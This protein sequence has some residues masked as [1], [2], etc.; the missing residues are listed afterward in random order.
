LLNRAREIR[1][2][3][4]W[5]ITKLTRSE[6]VWRIFVGGV[7][8]SSG[9][10][11]RE[12]VVSFFTNRTL[13]EDAWNEMLFTSSPF[14][15]SLPEILGWA[16]AAWAIGYVWLNAVYR[17]KSRDVTPA[18]LKGWERVVHERAIPLTEKTHRFHLAAAAAGLALFACA[19]AVSNVLA[20]GPESTDWL[21]GLLAAWIVG[22]ICAGCYN[23]GERHEAANLAKW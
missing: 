9:R 17:L 1:R 2:H 18:H 4:W 3:R 16:L 14:P 20:N 13:S 22:F 8:F 10:S 15:R 23:E 5:R 19:E 11:L 7:V 6:H 12:A 21:G